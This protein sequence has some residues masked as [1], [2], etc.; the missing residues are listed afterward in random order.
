[1]RARGA[2]VCRGESGVRLL[3]G[4]LHVPPFLRI[5]AVVDSR[6]SVPKQLKVI[7][8]SHVAAAEA[9]AD[10]RVDLQEIE[11]HRFACA[12][13][14]HMGD[15]RWLRQRHGIERP[16]EPGE[17]SNWNEF[18]PNSA[19]WDVAQ[20][21]GLHGPRIS[22]S[23]ACASGLIGIIPA[24]RALQI[25]NATWRGGAPKPSIRCSR[26]GFGRWA[27]WRRPMIRSRPAGPLIAAAAAL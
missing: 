8:L 18:L 9:M 26:R 1:M 27:S 24:V 25:I 2:P 3:E 11:P 6:P 16:D 12:V 15:W 22:H 21:F 7:H 23:T 19:C 17:A 10:A 13:S 14:G 4:M 5:G 20:R